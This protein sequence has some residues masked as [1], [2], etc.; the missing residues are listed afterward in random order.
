MVQQVIVGDNFFTTPIISKGLFKTSM[1]NCL[2]NA[3]SGERVS[4][5]LA[6]SSFKT[7]LF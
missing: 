3:S 6:A 4:N 5:N 1:A 2:P 7:T